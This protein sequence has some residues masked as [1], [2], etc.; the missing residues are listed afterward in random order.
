[1]RKLI[2]LTALCA[3]LP[4]MAQTPPAAPRF[5]LVS[6]DYIL[7]KSARGQVVTAE[8]RQLRES[9]N[10]RLKAKNDE[11]QRMAQQLKS[12]SLSEDGRAKLQRDLQ[13]ADTA[14]KRAEEDAQKEFAGARDKVGKAYQEEVLPIVAQVAKD[15]N[16]QVVFKL[17]DGLFEYVDEGAVIGFSEEVIK[18]YDAKFA[19]SA[20]PAAPVKKA[21]VKK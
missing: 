11:L 16:V 18:R 19:P 1:M 6:P 20:K 12:P 7:G 4:V 3:A 21:P 14:F 17:Q 15:W 9:L 8:L 10:E 13:D 2:T 5:A